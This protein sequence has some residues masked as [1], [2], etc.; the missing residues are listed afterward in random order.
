MGRRSTGTVEPLK[1]AIRLKFTH[2]GARRVETLD[3]PP[4]PANLKAA[5]RMLERIVGAIQAGVYRRADFF[6]ASGKAATQQIFRDYADAWLKTIVVAKSTRDS[7]EVAL[8]ASWNPAFGDMTLGEI[9]FSDVKKAV[10]GRAAKVSGKTINN[11]LIVLRGVFDTAMRDELISKDPTQGVENLKHQSPPPDP[12]EGRERDA[13]LAH[14]TEKF[15]EQVGN[16]FIVA[17][18]TGLRPS[19]QIALRWADIDWNRRKAKI[20]KARVVGEDKGTKTS[21]VREVDLSDAAIAALER[22]K[23]HTFMKNTPGS[24]H[25]FNNPETGK[26]WHDLQVQRR[27]YFTPT[28]TALKIRHRDM[29]QTR[30]TFATLLLMGGINPTYIA[31][32]LGHANTGMLFKVYGTWIEGAD[33]GAE[34]A[35]A[36]ALLGQSSTNRPRAEGA[37]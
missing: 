24:G 12:F 26:P 11:H 31:K 13:I 7:Y 22:Q 4:T 28:L 23:S 3:L 32:Q 10:A 27:R 21:T 2:L 16:Y 35:K 17:F 1:T 36:N 19:E 18:D 15:S 8:S 6:E 37:S 9:R 34:A 25:I 30:H 33:R 5:A 29:Y 20:S 14:M